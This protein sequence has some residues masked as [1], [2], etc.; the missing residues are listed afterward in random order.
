MTHDYKRNCATTLF[1]AHVGQG[2][3]APAPV[4]I[5]QTATAPRSESMGAS[6]GRKWDETSFF[7]GLHARVRGAVGE[8]RSAHADPLRVIWRTTRKVWLY[9]WTGGSRVASAK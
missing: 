9:D 8:R 4:L 6:S 7:D 3:S 1:A 2:R 5:G